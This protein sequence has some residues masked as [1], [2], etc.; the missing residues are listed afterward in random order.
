MSRLES[1]IRRCQAQCA[2]IERAAELMSELPGPVLELG[3]GNGRTY[4]HIREHLPDREI[5]VFDRQIAAHP[6]CIPDDDHIFLG[7]IT[8]TL[9]QAVKR[10]AGTIPL[11]HVDLGP[12]VVREIAAQI[13]K[14]LSPGGIAATQ[15]EAKTAGLVPLELPE[16]VA[17]GRY[18]LYR[19][20]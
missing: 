6:D 8:E 2:C 16:G 11:V 19:A 1:H 10:F 3:L 20:E 7:E 9:P 17:P 13:P 15:A 5:Y 14:L 18:F 4:S 12:E